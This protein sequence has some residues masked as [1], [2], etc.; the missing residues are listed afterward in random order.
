MK[1]ASIEMGRKELPDQ[2]FDIDPASPFLGAVTK[3]LISKGTLTFKNKGTQFTRDDDEKIKFSKSCTA[4]GDKVEIC[5]KKSKL[6]DESV[7]CNL[8]HT[9]EKSIKKEYTWVY[10]QFTWDEFEALIDWFGDGKYYDPR[11]REGIRRKKLGL[12][13]TGDLK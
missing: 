1:A 10:F 8:G 2:E 12:P 11:T 9:H 6:I 3:V 7:T 5:V 4:S 13:L